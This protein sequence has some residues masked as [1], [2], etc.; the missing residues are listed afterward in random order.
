MVPT[1]QREA[2]LTCWYCCRGLEMRLEGISDGVRR[3]SQ[4]GVGGG[5]QRPVGPA[6]RDAGGAVGVDLLGGRE[7]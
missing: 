2:R 1:E 5:G 3:L 6:V 4:G 7:E